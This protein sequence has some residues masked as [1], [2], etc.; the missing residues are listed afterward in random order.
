MGGV[1][2]DQ[3]VLPER[4]Y[5]WPSLFVSSASSALINRGWKILFCVERT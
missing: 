2:V 5:S 3:I 1:T 4:N